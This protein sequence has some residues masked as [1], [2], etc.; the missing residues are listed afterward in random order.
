MDQV[1]LVE[2]GAE[3]LNRIAEVFRSR[4]VPVTGVY[5]IKVTSQDE[6]EHWIIR[7]VV[8]RKTPDLTR[9]MIH[10]L[11]RLRRDNQL[12]KVDPSIRFDII[13]RTESEASRIID[14]ARS[15]GGPPVL[16]RDASWKGL[17]IEYALVASVPSTNVAV[18]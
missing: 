10:E 14:Y 5:L 13:P 11:V 15:L 7:L 2:D 16:I 8:D 12:P 4:G 1:T 3:G 17:F 6:F 9:K 18:A